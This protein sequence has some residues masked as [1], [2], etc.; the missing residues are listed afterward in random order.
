MKKV[1]LFTCETNNFDCGKWRVVIEDFPLEFSTLNI[2]NNLLQRKEKQV[3][4]GIQT[5]TAKEKLR[6]KTYKT[7]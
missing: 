4:L 5:T 6:K 2:L 7:N 1:I 3:K